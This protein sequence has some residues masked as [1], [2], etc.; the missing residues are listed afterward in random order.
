MNNRK[1]KESH[2]EIQYKVHKE[3]FEQPILHQLFFEFTLR[4]NEHCWHCG[5]R[6][7][8]I[9]AS[10]LSV[11]DWKGILDQV[12]D[13]FSHHLP[14]INVTGGE[15]LL[16]PG[17]EEVMSYAHELGFNWGM[18]SN[19]ILITPEVAQMLK[20]CGMDT[21][22]VSIDGL[23]QTHDALRGLPGAYRRAMDGVQNLINVGTFDAI[24]ITTV[25]NHE[26]IHELDDL[27]E[28]MKDL[29]IDY[30]RILGVEPIGRALEYPERAMTIEDQRTLFD[31]IRSKRAD[32]MPVSYGCS[33]YLGLDYE[34]EVRDW[35]FTCMAGTTI[36]SITCTGDVTGCLDIERTPS[37]IQGN[38]HDRRF[39]DI[40]KNEFKIFR[41]D[42]AEDNETCKNCQDRNY[43]MGG[44]C[45]TWDFDNSEQRV[46]LSKLWR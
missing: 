35:Y 23:E 33:H 6:C 18:T 11:A 36:A 21:I 5:S 45:H 19:A 20:R 17:F 40:W 1:L 25:V 24:M 10:E 16:Y 46:C 26:T 29:D 44:A 32:N 14:Q 13:D 34:R 28:I 22:S 9:Q 4:C 42:K 38:I 30:W 43:C 31:F 27:Y 41:R 12:K 2:L 39:S 3:L 15:P 8:D 7:G 37:V